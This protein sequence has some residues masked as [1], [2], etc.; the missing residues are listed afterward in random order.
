VALDHSS[1]SDVSRRTA[2]QPGF[3]AGI[4]VHLMR[5]HYHGLDQSTESTRV[6][7]VPID[8]THHPMELGL[9]LQLHSD[10][11]VASCATSGDSLSEHGHDLIDFDVRHHDLLG[12]Q[13]YR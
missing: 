1:H 8:R 2:R 12:W 4:E 13:S 9:Q 11:V 7:L 3:A 10:W 5:G 6:Y